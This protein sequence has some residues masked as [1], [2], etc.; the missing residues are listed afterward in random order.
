MRR[1]RRDQIHPACRAWF[2]FPARRRQLLHD[3]HLPTIVIFPPTAKIRNAARAL[4]NYKLSKPGATI[5]NQGYF[6]PSF[7]VECHIGRY[8]ESQQM[9]SVPSFLPCNPP[10]GL[11]DHPPH[12]DEQGRTP[13]RPSYR[14]RM[15]QAQAHARETPH[16]ICPFLADMLLLILREL[17]YSVTGIPSTRRCGTLPPLRRHGRKVRLGIRTGKGPSGPGEVAGQKD[18]TRDIASLCC[19]SGRWPWGPPSLFS[20]PGY[21]RPILYHSSTKSHC[22]RT[23]H[24]EGNCSGR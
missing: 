6:M 24:L 23:R 18:S 7:Q 5:S 10:A 9:F 11:P 17:I 16:Q 4:S 14:D 2:S 13:S 8:E 1:G 20:A 12:H 3:V 19:F 22:Y 15:S 21:S